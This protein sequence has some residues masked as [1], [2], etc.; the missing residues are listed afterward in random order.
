MRAAVPD[1]PRRALF[2]RRAL[3]SCA[4]AATLNG[5]VLLTTEE[6]KEDANAFYGVETPCMPPSC[7]FSGTDEA[8]A[9]DGA[10]GGG[11][12]AN[13]GTAAAVAGAGGSSG[14]DDLNASGGAPAAGGAGTGGSPAGGGW[15]AGANSTTTGDSPP[16]EGTSDSND[17]G[18]AGQLG[19]DP[20]ELD[21][22]LA[23]LAAAVA[24]GAGPEA[25]SQSG[26]SPT[27]MPARRAAK[28]ERVAKA[29]VLTSEDGANAGGGSGNGKAA[30]IIPD[31]SDDD[32]IARRLRRAA[33]L[34][35][36]P[37]IKQ[38]LWQEY[39]SYRQSAH[40]P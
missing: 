1:R 25:A 28:G 23:R 22:L 7:D 24:A 10:A 34:E 16:E 19:V 9:L 31:G 33:E 27:V 5:C 40:A 2:V 14:T 3:W 38:K 17:T 15:P 4:L 18:L 29:G 21:A 35:R 11:Q 37:S 36:D 6:T 26:A 12:A 39:L 8:A 13:A 32:I 30:Q 20:R